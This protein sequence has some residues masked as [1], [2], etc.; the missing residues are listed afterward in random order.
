MSDGGPSTWS[1]ADFIEYIDIHS[2]T[3][4]A[5]VAN[6]DVRRFLKL[7]GREMPSHLEQVAFIGCHHYDIKEMLADA[8]RAL[9][10]KGGHTGTIL[11]DLPPRQ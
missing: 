1:D 4:L 2:R 6:K 8:R 10:T 5:L 3:E 11:G 7:A 9:Q